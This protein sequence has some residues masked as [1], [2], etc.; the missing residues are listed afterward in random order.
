MNDD[1][2]N[3]TRDNFQD[4]GAVYYV[5]DTEL[6][7]I[8]SKKELKEDIY[9]YLQYNAI[10]NRNRN[11]EVKDVYEN[12]RKIPEMEDFSK[13]D[14]EIVYKHVFDNKYELE[15]GYKNF[16]PSYDMAQSFQ[17]LKD[18]KNIQKHDLTML[19]PERMEY[20]YMNKEKISYNETYAKT[21]LCYNYEKELIDYLKKK[22]D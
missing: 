17:R 21:I 10:K 14:V 22:G 2:I 9:A 13:E 12:I 7:N 18:D 5:I 1:G 19:R 11:K 6:D 20:D 4:S 15:G 16:D 8:K 3:K